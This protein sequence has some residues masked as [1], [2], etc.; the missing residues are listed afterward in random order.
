MQINQKLV[1]IQMISEV[2]RILRHQWKNIR[3]VHGEEVMAHLG[4]LKD[5]IELKANKLFIRLMVKF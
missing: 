3:V 2:L 1:N 5:L 4:S